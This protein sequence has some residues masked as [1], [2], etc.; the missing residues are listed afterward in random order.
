MS[1]K[2]DRP[3]RRA[4]FTLIEALVALAVAGLFLPVFAQAMFSAWRGTKAPMDV[5]SAVVY[6][7]A[8]ALDAAPETFRDAQER[9]YSIARKSGPVDVVVGPSGLAPSPAGI[10]DAE[11]TEP[12]STPATMLL[13]EPK[14]LITAAAARPKLALH[15]VAI[16]IGTPAGR[17]LRFDTVRLDDAAQ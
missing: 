4:G 7:R 14:A 12:R 3:G 6:A 15:A 16:V 8:A 11:P 9:G 13:A 5:V 10:A 17:R 2:G 1:P